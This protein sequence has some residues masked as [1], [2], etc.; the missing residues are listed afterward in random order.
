M[1]TP[2]PPGTLRAQTYSAFSILFSASNDP[3]AVPVTGIWRILQGQIPVAC[4]GILD[5]SLLF[6]LLL[7][8]VQFTTLFSIRKEKNE[9]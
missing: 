9:I 3:S 5:F 4:C 7:F 6:L 2:R 1:A 8:P